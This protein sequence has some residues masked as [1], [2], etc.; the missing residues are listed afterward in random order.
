MITIDSLTVRHG[1]RTVLD[2]VTMHLTERAVHAL[3]GIDGAG[4]TTLLDTL[5]GLVAPAAGSASRFGRPLRRRKM[6]YLPCKELRYEGMTGRDLLDLAARYH[7]GDDP[8]AYARLFALPIDERIGRWPTDMKKKLAL[9][10]ALMQRTPIL[11]LDEP[12][13]G[14]DTEGL[15]TAQRLI[16]RRQAAG[17]TLLVAARNFQPL[18]DIAD[19]LYILD[20][21]RI[22]G[23]YRREEFPHAI[24]ALETLSGRGYDGTFRKN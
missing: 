5:F 23:A 16:L 8:A 20:G 2:G 15:R 21:G 12:F 10:V 6:T 22:A 3:V 18:A 9:T 4:K 19:D 17:T 14:L 1:N 11:L 13:D 7:P 24:R